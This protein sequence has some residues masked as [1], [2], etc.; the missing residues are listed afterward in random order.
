MEKKLT[1]SISALAEGLPK[2]FEDILSYIRGLYFNSEPDYKYLI[3]KLEA[4]AER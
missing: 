2:E 3:E 4:I 1:I